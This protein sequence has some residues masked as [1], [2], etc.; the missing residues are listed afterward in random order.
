M[1]D[2]TYN[3]Q[4]EKLCKTLEFGDITSIP[5]QVSGGLLHR[6]YALETTCGKFAVKAL[7]P[8]IMLRPVAMQHYINSERIVEIAA[9]HIP[10]L[11]SIRFEGTYLHNIDNQ[12]YL[13]FDWIDGKSLKPGEINMMHCEK[14]GAILAD[15]HMIDFSKLNIAYDL[16]EKPMLTDWNYYLQRDSKVKQFGQIFCL[17]ILIALIIGIHKQ[18][19]HLSFLLLIW[20]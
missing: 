12:Y 13:V 5:E 3:V 7:N 1:S 19:K 8:R 15:L 17:N 4:F 14:I 9:K 16:S 10:A 6:M 18:M 11:P 20:L 2:M